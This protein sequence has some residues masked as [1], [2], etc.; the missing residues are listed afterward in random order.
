ME[1]SIVFQTDG[2]T[3]QAA[4]CNKSRAL[5]KVIKSILSIESFKQKCVI[6]RAAFQS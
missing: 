5:I 1:K 4:D 2:K 6:L 3:L